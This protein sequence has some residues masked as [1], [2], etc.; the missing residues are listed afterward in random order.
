MALRCLARGVERAAQVLD[1]VVRML[2]ADRK[3]DHAFGDP[4]LRELVRRHPEVRRRRRMN[5]ERRRIAHVS[6]V[7]EEPERLDELPPLRARP[8]ELEA[9][10]GSATLRQEP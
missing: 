2:E 1:Q 3:A 8:P 6:E 7:R 4:G 10:N 5:D 9:E